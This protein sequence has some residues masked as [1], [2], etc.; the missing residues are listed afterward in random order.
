MNTSI[1]LN[2]IKGSLF[3]GAAGDA[4]GGPIEPW[5]NDMD[6]IKN[7]FGTTRVETLVDY[8]DIDEPFWYFG[9]APKG[10]YT[11]DTIVKNVVCNSIIKNRGRIGAEQFAKTYCDE[12]RREYFI[13]PKG[14]LWPGQALIWFK[15]YFYITGQPYKEIINMPVYR[16]MGQGS[17]PAGDAAMI[18]SPIGLINAGDPFQAAM[19][20]MEVSSVLQ[21]GNQVTATAA[22]AAAVAVAM[23]PGATLDQV[24]EAAVKYTDE[25][26]GD[27]IQRAIDLANAS[28]D[29][30]AF[31]KKF[32]D[33]LLIKPTDA[34]ELVP[35]AFGLLAL[36]K[37]DYVRTVVEA[38]NFQR[39]VD[40]IAGV[41]GSISGAWL[42]LD[43]I[44]PDW[45]DAV[46]N[47]NQDQP[48]QDDLAL[49]IYDALCHEREKQ[50]A[51][52]QLLDGIL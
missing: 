30:E 31:K 28:V 17:L 46:R 33:E 3:G 2:K 27:R 13:R 44:P 4:L 21:S 12:M 35:E 52:I 50:N 23:M 48:G 24:F 19:D 26:T 9:P 38:T 40:T 49:G 1:A 7:H 22:I 34:L 37:G 5:V 47:A 10:T 18:I 29:G 11:D 39:D 14:Q 15:M 16:D 8:N 36:A 51:H 6:F 43:A 20:A 25:E 45:V 32:Y 42:G 41:A